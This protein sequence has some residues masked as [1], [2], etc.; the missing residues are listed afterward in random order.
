MK[1]KKDVEAFENPVVSRLSN[2]FVNGANNR[3]IMVKR[4]IYGRC[5]RQLLESK[6]MY[7]PNVEISKCAEEPRAL[8]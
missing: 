4:T 2:G 7:R 8:E 1:L 5:T 6:L 3:F